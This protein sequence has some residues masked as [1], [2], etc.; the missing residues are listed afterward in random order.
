MN[1][2]DETLKFLKEHGRTIDEIVWIGN[3]NGYIEVDEFLKLADFNYDD[4]YGR[5]EVRLDICIYGENF[6]MYRN[7][8]DSS[9]WWEIKNALNKPMNKMAVTTLREEW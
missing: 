1:L 3:S 9:E 6:I 4:G 7:V 5:N 2:K 8:Y